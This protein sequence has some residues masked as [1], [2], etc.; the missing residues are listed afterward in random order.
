MKRTAAVCLLLFAAASARADEPAPV[1]VRFEILKSKHM[2]VMV[3]VNGKGPYRLIFDTG[4]PYNLLSRKVGGDAGLGKK[5]AGGLA[6]PGMGLYKVK[7]LQ[8][9]DVKIEG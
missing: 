5:K 1:K 3:K 9:G 8:V 6:L 2:A 7:S 4:A